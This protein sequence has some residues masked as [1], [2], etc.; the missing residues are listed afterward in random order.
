MREWILS[1]INYGH[2]KEHPYEVALLPMG[3]T[4]P[5]NLHLPYGTDT[6]EAEAI[7]SRAC[8]AA[9]KQGARVVMLPA[10]P[11]GT[12]TNQLRFPLAM[13]VNPSTLLLVI[14]D[15]VDSLAAHGIHKLLILNSHGG[16]DF[17]PVLRELHGK[18]PVHIF[19]CDWYRGTSADVQQTIFDDPG[20]HAG[21]METALALAYF[22]D[23]VA[24]DPKTGKLQADEGAV[25]PTRFEAVNRGWISLTRPWHLLTTN[26]GSGNPH[27]ATAEKGRAFMQTLVERISGFLVELANSPIDERFPF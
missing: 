9:Y 17:K 13:N 23:L 20:D 12:D 7:S 1:E 24:V 14:R 10:I 6:Y 5:H 4:E 21:E 26:S 22:S 11:Y 16:N 2:V 18:T 15:L 3:A 8:E 27:P 25:N 19:L